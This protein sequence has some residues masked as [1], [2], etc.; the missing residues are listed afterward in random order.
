MY[1]A[2]CRTRLINLDFKL[3]D[4]CKLW[5]VAAIDLR[6]FWEYVD[7]LLSDRS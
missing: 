3:K 4:N 5:V 1:L 7:A 6:D 2:L